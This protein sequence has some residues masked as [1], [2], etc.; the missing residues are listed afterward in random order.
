MSESENALPLDKSFWEHTKHLDYDIAIPVSPKKMLDIVGALEDIYNTVDKDVEEGKR[1]LVMLASIFVASA[2]GKADEVFEE[3]EVRE[4]MRDI[5]KR[6][7]EILDE[8]P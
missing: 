1:C 6:L 4:N 5:D 2:V 8:K 7:K 3:F